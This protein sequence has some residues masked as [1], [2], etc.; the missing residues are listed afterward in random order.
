MQYNY[1]SMQFI[2]VNMQHKYIDMQH[3]SQSHGNIAN[4]LVDIIMFHVDIGAEVC[5]HKKENCLC[6]VLFI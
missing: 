5:H 1:V 3:K 6:Y 4:S 2:Y